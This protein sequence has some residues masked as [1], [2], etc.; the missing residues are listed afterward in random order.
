[1]GVVHRAMH[2]QDELYMEGIAYLVE[3]HSQRK[4]FTKVGSPGT[5]WL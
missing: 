5:P 4:L 2:V 3:I 1:M